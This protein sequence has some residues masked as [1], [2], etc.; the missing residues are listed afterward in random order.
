M[1]C[2]LRKRRAGIYI[3]RNGNASA[4]T[5][6]KLTVRAREGAEGLRKANLCEVIFARCLEGRVSG[7]R[8]AP[9]LPHSTSFPSPASPR[10]NAS[11]CTLKKPCLPA[12]LPFWE[13]KAG[14]VEKK[15]CER[16]I[17]PAES[18]YCVPLVPLIVVKSNE[19]MR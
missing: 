2:H 13:G 16:G 6:I 17:F 4:A 12:N 8:E 5:G 14:H 15:G 9:S 19:T 3:A 10:K 18:D 1:T 11:I 7:V